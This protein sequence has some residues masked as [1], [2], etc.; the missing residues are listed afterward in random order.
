MSI[1]SEAFYHLRAWVWYRG[2]IMFR[3]KKKPKKKPC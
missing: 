2:E 1:V 3:K